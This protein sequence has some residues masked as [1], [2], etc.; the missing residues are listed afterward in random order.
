[1]ARQMVT[2]QQGPSGLG[3]FLKGTGQ[4]LQFSHGGRNEGFDAT[5]Q[6]FAETG[7][8]AAI[9][10]N[11]NDNS[12]ATSRILDAIGREYHWPSATPLPAIE[13]VKLDAA[14]IARVAGRYELANNQMIVLVP[15]PESD[16][17]FTLAD[18]TPDEELVPVS[19]TRFLARHGNLELEVLSERG[20]V[21]GFSWVRSGSSGKAPRIGP[22]VGTRAAS[23]DPD[24]AL[25]A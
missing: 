13:M 3:V 15:G 7:Q 1:M 2:T 22:L 23:K 11:T 10:I 17:L 8:A 18:G 20:E 24:S 5:W 21:V 14:A 4:A 9:M 12:F 25:T 6:A 16:R 19:P